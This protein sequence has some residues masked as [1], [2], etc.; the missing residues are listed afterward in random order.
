MCKDIVYRYGAKPLRILLVSEN[1]PPQVN[2]IA[3]HI[4][5]ALRGRLEVFGLRRGSC[6]PSLSIRFQQPLELDC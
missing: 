4:G 6:C 2:G 1:V 5:W 3:R